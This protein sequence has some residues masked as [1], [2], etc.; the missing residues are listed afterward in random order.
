MRNTT[1]YLLFLLCCLPSA[2][3]QDS[4]ATSPAKLSGAVLDS[5]ANPIAYANIFLTSDEGEEAK[6]LAGGHSDEQGHFE[7]EAPTG[8]YTISVSC[9]GYKTYSRGVQ[10][11]SS[12]QPLRIVLLED[13]Q[14]LQS[15]VV[16]GRALRVK[17]NPTGFVIDVSELKKS[18][19][20]ALDLLAGLPNIYVKGDKIT[21]AGKDELVV[22]IGK[23]VQRVPAS[24]LGRLLKS[25]DAELIQQ[26]EVMMQP[27]SR[28]DK[29]GNTAMIILTMTSAFNEYFG[30]DIG[31]ELIVGKKQHRIGGFGALIYNRHNLSFSVAPYY[32]HTETPFEETF[33]YKAPSYERRKKDNSTGGRHSTGISGNV[34]Y[35]YSARG[36]VGV[37]V[38][39]SAMLTRNRFNP[40]ERF[41]RVSAKTPDSIS[42][43]TNIYNNDTYKLSAVAYLEQAL[44]DKGAKM[45]VDA[46]YYDYWTK[47]RNTLSA[48]MLIPSTGKVNNAYYHYIDRDAIKTYGV[49]SNIDFY[50]PLLPEDKLLI[51]TGSTLSWSRTNNQ[52]K[53]EE[54]ALEEQ[55][56]LFVY[57]EGIIAPYFSITSRIEKVTTRL[58]IKVP[59]S[60]TRSEQ[61]AVQSELLRTYANYLP[62]LHLSYMPSRKHKI[63]ASFNSSI[64]R[65]Q[66]EKINP[67]VWKTSKYSQTFGNPKL[68]PQLGYNT[69]LRYIYA[70]VIAL[71]A[72]LDIVRDVIGGVTEILPNG[73]IA[74][75][76]E[77]TQNG[78]FVGLSAS[79]YFDHLWWFQA[80]FNATYGNQSYTSKVQGLPAVV[81]GVKWGV[82]SYLDFVFNKARTFTGYAYAD[83]TSTVESAASTLSPE[84]NL[85]LGISYNLFDR[86][87]NLS[88]SGINLI[89]SRY[90]GVQRHNNTEMHFDHRFTFPSIYFS[91]SYKFGK[92]ERKRPSKTT[93]DRENST[94]F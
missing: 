44:S 4:K 8:D 60:I 86:R 53:R 6:V 11:T 90:K 22:Q 83:Y 54:K 37:V 17:S 70:G 9:L 74:F 10:V 91:A 75:R 77:N 47:S 93:S 29:N 81:S 18:R 64:T 12:N 48:N 55:H 3:A 67:F 58:G 30:G 38:D 15:V 88:L 51:E 43:A 63:N 45:W 33:H 57:D 1:L 82:S 66:F 14:E 94:R 46:A 85:G 50:L 89:S 25:Y 80:S 35:S 2:F 28:Y 26:V 49:S 65:P 19:N 61:K 71:G 76:P 79:Y 5:L 62:Y 20:N 13:S 87:L 42:L 56:S 31:T 7:I 68:R 24:A 32:N 72:N 39:Y 40:E 23:V 27:P 16:Q 41:Y 92:A 52:R 21:V 78:R 69:Q 36:H 73:I 34:Q 59:V 84:Y